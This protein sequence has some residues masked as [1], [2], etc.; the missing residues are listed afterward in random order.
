ME[1][2]RRELVV[3]PTNQLQTPS[4]DFKRADSFCEHKLKTSLEKLGI[5]KHPTVRCIADDK[6]EI[7]EGRRIV[8]ALRQLGQADISAY[9]LGKI[10]DD[11]AKA[12]NL[13]LNFIDF[14]PSHAD[15]AYLIYTLSQNVELNKLCELLPFTK[16]EIERFIE[17]SKFDWDQYKKQ[18]T[19]G[20]I[21]MFS[22]I[23]EVEKEVSA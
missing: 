5:L 17:I 8:Q 22:V 7:V 11:E 15:I 10:T 21:D 18:Y 14:D 4:Y 6:Y 16:E 3:I 13:M 9:N 12:V 19:N 20:Q 1:L 23:S 2:Q